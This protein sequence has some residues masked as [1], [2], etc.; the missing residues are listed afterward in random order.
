MV[1]T[2]TVAG[3]PRAIAVSPDGTT[4]YV[5]DMGTFSNPVGHTVYRVDLATGRVTGQVDSGTDPCAMV[6][7]DGILWVS[8]DG[9]PTAQVPGTVLPITAAT[10]TAQ[11]PV[12]VG[13]RPAGMAM[14]PDGTHL[15][16]TN[17]GNPY[18]FPDNLGDNDVPADGHQT[19]SVIDVSSRLVTGRSSW[20]GPVEHRHLPRRHPG[21]GGERQVRLAHPDRPGQRAAR[22]TGPGP[23]PPPRDRPDRP[24][25]SGPALPT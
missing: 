9:S 15:Y 13:F 7:V 4:A 21:L 11:A 23:R 1:R 2:Y 20:G 24:D 22:P 16:V 17:S 5:A 3:H 8:V 12:A 25:V 14:T 18:T 10:M 19:V 6:L